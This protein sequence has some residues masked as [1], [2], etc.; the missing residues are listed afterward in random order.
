MP[1]GQVAGG[2]GLEEGGAEALLMAV[3]ARQCS[4]RSRIAGYFP[5]CGTP[6]EVV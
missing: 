3:G 4:T 2:K 1:L 6:T 5:A